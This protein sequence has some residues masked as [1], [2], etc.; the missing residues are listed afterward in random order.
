MKSSSIA[1]DVNEE[2]ERERG[3]R[4]TDTPIY[5]VLKPSMRVICMRLTHIVRIYSHCSNITQIFA[6]PRSLDRVMSIISEQEHCFSI[7]IWYEKRI[8]LTWTSWLLHKLQ[9]NYQSNYQITITSIYFVFID[10][11]ILSLLHAMGGGILKRTPW[12]NEATISPFRI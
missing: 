10:I 8:I 6:L 4:K 5:N 9:I 1:A 3:A 7:S 11:P 12:P 2:R